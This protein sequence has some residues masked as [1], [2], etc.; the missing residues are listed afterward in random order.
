MKKSLI[1]GLI[2]LFCISF[3]AEAQVLDPEYGPR[4]WKKENAK[5]EVDVTLTHIR[6][7]DVMWAKRIWRVID[8]RQ[9]QNL[10]LYYPIADSATLGKRSFIQLIYDEIKGASLNPG[11]NSLKVYSDYQ[12]K[13]PIPTEQVL[14]RFL[15]VDTTK[16]IIDPANCT[17]EEYTEILDFQTKLKPDIY[18]VQIMEDWFFDKQRSV[19]DVRILALAIEFPL[20]T[21]KVEVD[22]VCSESVF[23]GW[24]KVPNAVDRI[25]FFFPDLRP[26][27][28]SNECYKRFNDAGRITYDDIFLKR[29]FDSYIIKEENVYD[30]YINDYTNNLNALLEA[31]KISNGIREFEQDMWQY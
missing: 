26:V 2:S 16:R 11:P 14:S 5:Q 23:G 24:E 29:M 6:E 15:K 25:W 18:R 13:S 20:Y 17:V 19:M 27:M 22:P 31:E 1:I 8:L 9:K 10:P 7:A 21:S 28:A 12:L 30:R 4:A 3:Y